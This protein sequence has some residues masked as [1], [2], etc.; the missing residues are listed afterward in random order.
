MTAGIVNEEKK[1]FIGSEMKLRSDNEFGVLTS[2]NQ[3]HPTTRNLSKDLYEYG[4]GG[5]SG[6]GINGSNS[7][8]SIN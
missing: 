5:G 4:G 7:M 3:I 1:T 6:S 2:S 8:S